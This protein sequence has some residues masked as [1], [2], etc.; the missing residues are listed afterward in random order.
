MPRVE[1]PLIGPSYTNR[2]KPLS[3]QVAKNMW[4]EINPE[5]RNQV[6]LHNT[7]GIRTFA[8]LSGI[9]RGMTDFNN[10][11][12]AVSGQTLYSIDA[13]GTNFALGTI[14]GT[15]RVVM[16][17]DSLQL[18][19]TT[20]A[21]PYKYTVA[22]GVEEITDP[23]LVNPTTVAYLNNQFIFDQ[24]AGVF[25]EFV[26]SSVDPEF[27]VDAL[28]FAQAESH[29][30][31]IIAI[32]AFRQLVYFFGSHSVEP[33]QNT[34]VG[35]PPFARV[36]SGVQPYGLAGLHGVTKTDEFMYYLDTKRIPRRSNGLNHLNI[37]N[38]A[39]GVEFAKYTKIDDVIAF[40]FVQDNQQFVAF[41]FPTADRTWC[42]HEPSGSWFELS[43]I[44]TGAMNNPET[45]LGTFAP[46]YIGP[47]IADIEYTVNVAITP[48]S[49]SGLF[50]GDNIVYSLVGSWPTGL[51]IDSGTGVISGTPTGELQA[52]PDLVVRATNSFGSADATGYQITLTTDTW[53][54]ATLVAAEAS[55]DPWLDG[56]QV[57]ITGGAVY[58]F[59]ANTAVSGYSGLVH[60]EPYGSGSGT[61]SAATVHGSEIA[62]IDP[63]SWTGWTDSST[64]VKS[65]D[66]EFDT[67]S[68]LS[69]MRD[70]TTAG[71]AKLITDKKVASGDTEGFYIIDDIS[72]TTT[73]SAV[74][75]FLLTAQ[76]QVYKDGVDR[77]W[78]NLEGTRDATSTNWR[79]NHTNGSTFATSSQS[80]T[81]ASRAFLYVKNG[82]WAV[83]FNADSTPAMSGTV[84]REA[85]DSGTEEFIAHQAGSTNSGVAT[86]LLGTQVFGK[87][88]TA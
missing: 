48:V 39:L 1:I 56:N 13:E 51:S 4:P 44:E 7:A 52:Y 40:D 8:T 32:V 38:P 17:N 18:I 10:L 55:G 88:T 9:D 75:S 68:N 63:D 35:N 43:Y 73:I 80:R 3:A 31:D 20:G 28:D 82:R 67:D 78:I 27:S 83:W 30:D 54:Y 76:L 59:I 42:F 85:T 72:G 19:I 5:A 26:T 2:E 6:A 66:Y 15:D 71:I 46:A 79:C 81:A 29:P 34:G 70:L 45:P 84:P 69:R 22:N 16:A 65:T 24:N 36:N 14:A 86:L 47:D 37:G 64:G 25:G 57:T 87:M 77:N 41:T 62:D 12:Y 49:T 33:W 61:L 11:M 21:T 74:A 53:E 23:D 58:L 50:V 60:R